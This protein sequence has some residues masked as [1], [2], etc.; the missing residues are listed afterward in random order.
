MVMPW[1]CAMV[2]SIVMPGSI[3]HAM[4]DFSCHGHAMVMHGMVIYIYIAMGMPYMVNWSCHGRFFYAMVKWSGHA[5]VI[6]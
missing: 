6:L 3:G 2:M 4:V 1:S 5:L